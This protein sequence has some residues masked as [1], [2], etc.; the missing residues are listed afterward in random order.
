MTDLDR[1]LELH[2]LSGFPKALDKDGKI[3]LWNLKAKIDGKIEKWDNLM[4]I[5]GGG[6]RLV[7]GLSNQKIALES[8]VAKL[9][10]DY[11]HLLQQKKDCEDRSYSF[12]NQVAKLKEEK[13]K[14]FNDYQE[15][16]GGFCMLEST[17]DEIKTLA[18][19]EYSDKYDNSEKTFGICQECDLW[20]KLKE[21]LAKHEDKK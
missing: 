8:Q 4:S 17:L 21:I 5:D 3:E 16:Y 20:D 18:E 1:L 15:L 10:R 7:G 2:G 12:E 9:Q 14:L 6:S 13:D 19:G 11:S